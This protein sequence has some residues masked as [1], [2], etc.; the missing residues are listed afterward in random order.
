MND[1]GHEQPVTLIEP[2][3]PIVGSCLAPHTP[4]TIKIYLAGSDLPHNTNEALP[5]W[6]HGRL[7][8]RGMGSQVYRTDF[9]AKD[10]GKLTQGYTMT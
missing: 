5:A 8:Y 3:I 7:E 6:V 10:D 4:V 1:Q 2:I 9:D